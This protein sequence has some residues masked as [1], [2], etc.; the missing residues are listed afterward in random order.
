MILFIDTSD[1][2]QI[3][4]ALV[5]KG[6]VKRQSWKEA[7][8]ASETLTQKIKLMLNSNKTSLFEL[9]KLAVVVGPGHF[10]RIRTAV[11][12]VNALAFVLKIPVISLKKSEVG[13]LAKISS[14]SGKILAKPAYGSEPNITKPKKRKLPHM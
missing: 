10:S 7:S 9:K 4:M 6:K 14:K 12:T 13:S 1:N 3:T 11:A 5:E 2:E 8:S